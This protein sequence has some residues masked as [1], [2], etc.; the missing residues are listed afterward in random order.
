MG[1][2]VTFRWA[3]SQVRAGLEIA[4]LSSRC[5]DPWL[6]KQDRLLRVTPSMARGLEGCQQ[7]LSSW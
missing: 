5:Q 2:E 1:M 7:A 4:T 3:A 6:L